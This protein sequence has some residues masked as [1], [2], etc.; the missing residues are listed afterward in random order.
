MLYYPTHLKYATVD[1][2]GRPVK[3]EIKQDEWRLSITLSWVVFLFTYVFLNFL[4]WS[5][6]HV[7]SDSVFFA[8]VTFLLL[9]TESSPDSVRLVWWAT[10]LGVSS[11]LL[12]AFQYFPQIVHTYRHKVVGALSI[13]MMCIQTPGA[14]LMVTSIAIRYSF[15]GL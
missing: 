3:T 11:T 2:D 9:G 8:F 4:S 7:A 14:I 10:F 5:A 15:V 12:A 1:V 13:P 6:K